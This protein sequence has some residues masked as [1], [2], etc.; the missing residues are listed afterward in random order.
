M[1]YFEE[2]DAQD[3]II[4][5]LPSVLDGDSDMGLPPV[6]HET[7]RARIERRRAR[8]RLYPCFVHELVIQ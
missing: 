8:D 6:A 7:L 3:G 5:P 4:L 1:P 2:H